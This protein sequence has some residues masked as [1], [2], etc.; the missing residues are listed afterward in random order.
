M[1]Y[2]N[3]VQ[4][5]SDIH[6]ERDD[7]SDIS[8]IITPNAEI[9]VLAGDIGNPMKSIY[10]DFLNYYS[11]LFNIIFIITG[12]HEYYGNSMIETNKKIEEICNLYDNIYF[13]NNKTFKYEGILFI[14]TTL[15]SLIPEDYTVYDQLSSMNDFK[16]IKEFT[17]EE[18]R[19]LFINNV[20][21]IKNNLEENSIIITHHAPSMKCIAEEYKY[22]KVNCCFASDL[23]ELFMNNK[24]IGWIYGHTHN[25]L[26]VISHEKFMYSNCY[27]TNN[28]NLCGTVI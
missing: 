24:V 23:D 13:L 15:W 18:Y 27:R 21:F 6:L 12:N 20:K 5:C 11:K 1:K 26:S 9:L 7:I 3:L 2:N 19:K 22:D 8:K 25:N 16:L 10:N 28:Y 4:V 14:G 17:L